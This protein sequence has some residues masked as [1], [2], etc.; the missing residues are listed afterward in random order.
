MTEENT[1]QLLSAITFLFI[2]LSA[3]FNKKF[4]LFNVL[5]FILYTAYLYYSLYY[6]GREG[7]S[8]AWVALIYLATGIHLFLVLCYL[9]YKIAI[10]IL[11]KS[12]KG[13][14]GRP[15]QQ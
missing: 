15:H 1:L 4:S 6:D 8:M 13:K 3:K 12:F 9:V 7:K 2:V 14:S 5:G 11:Q 10:V